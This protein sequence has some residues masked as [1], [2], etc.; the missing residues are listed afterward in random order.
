M[1]GNAPQGAGN[2]YGYKNTL[3]DFCHIRCSL[4][5][6]PQGFVDD[7]PLT[8]SGGE[9]NALDLRRRIIGVLGEALGLRVV[10]MRHMESR[11]VRTPLVEPLNCNDE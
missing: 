3:A 1:D 11:I 4:T 7:P 6:H 5:M 10:C 2:T 9:L 8:D